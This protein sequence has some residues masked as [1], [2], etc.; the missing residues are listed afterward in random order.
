M[1]RN[2]YNIY[3]CFFLFSKHSSLSVD[4]SA[5]YSQRVHTPQ[6]YYYHH[7]AEQPT[8][9][10]YQSQASVPNEHQQKSLVPTNDPKKCDCKNET[11]RFLSSSNQR[12]FYSFFFVIT[13]D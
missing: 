5:A 8:F 13:R 6:Q 10:P 12:C 2:K 7:S 1:I 11:N 4:D 9:Y 3:F